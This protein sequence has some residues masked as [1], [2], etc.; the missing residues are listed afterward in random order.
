MVSRHLNL[1]CVQQHNH[2]DDHRIFLQ[3]NHLDNHQFDPLDNPPSNPLE[4]LVDNLL[5]SQR[6]NL[7]TVHLIN[8]VDNLL[9]SP[10][11]DLVEIQP[12]SRQGNQA[13]N[14]LDNLHRS[15]HRNLLLD[16]PHNLHHVHR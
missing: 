8:R 13:V 4:F 9:F 16:H 2:L 3:H 14:H 12:F 5:F 15:L 1:Q 11:R 10:L 7:L 6:D